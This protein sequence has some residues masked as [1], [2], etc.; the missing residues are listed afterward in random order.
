MAVVIGQVISGADN[1]DIKSIYMDSLANASVKDRVL[2]LGVSSDKD[3][4]I[5]LINTGDAR[6][7]KVLRAEIGTE[8]SL[9]TP[10]INIVTVQ[11]IEEILESDD[12][13][14]ILELAN[15]ALDL[16]TLDARELLSCNCHSFLPI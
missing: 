7:H 16:L 1:G 15:D 12:A 4:K 11:A 10:H 2:S 3:E 8:L 6:V 5:R 14:N 13:F 9:I